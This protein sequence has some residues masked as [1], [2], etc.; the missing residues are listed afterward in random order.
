ML[1]SFRF[2]F[3]AA[4]SALLL[5][6]M[7]PLT[8]S[9]SAGAPVSTHGEA[10][11]ENGPVGS[12]TTYD[13][14]EV[15]ILTRAPKSGELLTGSCFVIEAMLTHHHVSNEGCDEN[16]D[17]QVDFKG[18]APG[19]YMVQQTRATAGYRFMEG[20]SII[21][22]SEDAHQSFPAVQRWPQNDPEHRTVTIVLSIPGNGGRLSGSDACV[23]VEGASKE[24]CDDNGDGQIDFL[25][26]PVGVYPV[27]VTRLPAGYQTLPFSGD[28][29]QIHISDMDLSI[30]TMYVGVGKS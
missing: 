12:T 9:A 26:V 18:I 20:F 14:V 11:W 22:T 6:N 23:I 21:V 27:K 28:S 10:R 7:L 13:S 8:A 16:G 2:L 3:I 25:D 1:Q 5:G 19:Q 17:G 15:S 24:G 30:V 29:H 4:A